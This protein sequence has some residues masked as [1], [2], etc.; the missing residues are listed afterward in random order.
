MDDDITS[1]WEDEEED[2]SLKKLAW[3][4]FGRSYSSRLNL[5]VGEV[6]KVMIDFEVMMI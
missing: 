3:E 1:S 6:E 5:L 4:S 2:R